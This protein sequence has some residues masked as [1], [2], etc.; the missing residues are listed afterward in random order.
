MGTRVNQ[1]QLEAVVA[2]INRITKSPETSYTKIGDKFKANIGN[3][4]LDYAY[5]GVA[6]HRMVSDGGGITDVLRVGHVPKR[7]I[8]NLMFAYIQ[9]LEDLGE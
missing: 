6:L 7:E 4:H 1:K 2:R 5:G 3:Y 8:L 9:G